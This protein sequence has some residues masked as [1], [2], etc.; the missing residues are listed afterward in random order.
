MNQILLFHLLVLGGQA[1]RGFFRFGGD[2][3]L[4]AVLI[5]ET[6]RE[7]ALV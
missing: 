7:S 1:H 6:L 3:L 5:E 2:E 4:H